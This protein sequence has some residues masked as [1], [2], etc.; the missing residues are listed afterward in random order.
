MAFRLML[1]G[2]S[3]VIVRLFHF[4]LFL[5]LSIYVDV[6]S[7]NFL[8]FGMHTYSS[9]VYVNVCNTRFKN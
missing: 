6:R 9:C 3:V 4:A 5:Y 2:R 8:F 1:L 7:A